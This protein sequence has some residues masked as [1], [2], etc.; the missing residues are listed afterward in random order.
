[1]HVNKENPPDVRIRKCYK[2]WPGKVLYLCE[3]RSKT[4][5]GKD[6]W[7]PFSINTDYVLKPLTSFDE[8]SQLVYKE[9]SFSK[10]MIELYEEVFVG[11][12]IIK[13]LTFTKE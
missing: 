5:F 10:S 11:D 6:K 3:I 8:E 1:M 9:L 13:T 4:V 2:F 7:I 12:G